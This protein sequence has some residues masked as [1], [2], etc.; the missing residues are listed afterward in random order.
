MPEV[1]VTTAT[2][3]AIATTAMPEDVV[4]AISPEAIV[5]TA[6]PED[7]VI[8]IF[9]EAIA[10]TAMSEDVEVK[11]THFA[12]PEKDYVIQQTLAC[13]YQIMIAIW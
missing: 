13:L 6:M 11:T 5:T 3:E 12:C 7:V 1:I 2:P 8:A 9:P 4:I 10:K